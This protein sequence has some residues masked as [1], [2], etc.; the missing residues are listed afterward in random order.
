LGATSAEARQ[1]VKRFPRLNQQQMADFLSMKAVTLGWATRNGIVER[2]GDGSYRPEIVTG[3]WLKYERGRAAKKAGRS[4]FERQR[5]RLTKM[6][7]DVVERRLC[8]LD[9][10]LV[11][12]DDIVAS[13]KTVCLRIKSKLQAALPRI[14]RACYH[15]PNLTEALK[16]SRAEFDVLISELSTL[17]ND[18]A[19]TQFEVV[20]A[21]GASAKGSTT[22]EDPDGSVA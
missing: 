16:G 1:L 5:V 20:N 19:P 4:E 21:D 9:G 15:A 17:E 18:T 10:S 3:Q 22:G 11:G 13:M 14:T 7:A 2:D 12:T 8:Q 6:K